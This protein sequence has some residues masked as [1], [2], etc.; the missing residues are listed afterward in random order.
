MPAD[1]R[2]ALGAAAGAG[3]TPQAMPATLRS[4]ELLPAREEFVAPQPLRATLLALTPALVPAALWAAGVASAGAATATG[5]VLF[6]LAGIRGAYA[7]FDARRCRALADRLLRAH[8]RST[9]PSPLADWRATQLT[10]ERTRRRLV[11]RLQ[12]LIHEAE[13]A[14]GAC[15][16]PL[17][18][19]ALEQSLF[20]LRRLDRRLGDLSRPVSP[21]GILVVG[22]LV[23]GGSSPLSRPEC[24]AELPDA[25]T[26]A[27]AALD[28]PR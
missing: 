2:F 18:R 19:H 22:E 12:S 9:V 23:D 26:E 28:A 21:Y 4:Y 3:R 7:W 8:G 16:S 10:S 14:L 5:G 27:L 1:L 25:S 15:S 13:L 24:A 6:G 17:D 11:K 20:L